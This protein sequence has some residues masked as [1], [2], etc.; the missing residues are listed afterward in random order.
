MIREND[1]LSEMVDSRLQGLWENNFN[2]GK[3]FETCR[4]RVVATFDKLS[5]L[6]VDEGARKLLFEL[7][8]L[9]CSMASEEE[10]AMYKQGFLDGIKIE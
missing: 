6:L 5:A 2:Y 4:D 9:Y 3:E 8:A 1:V 10:R 7:D